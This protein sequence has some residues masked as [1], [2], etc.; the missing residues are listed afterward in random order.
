MQII[1]RV[2]KTR[3]ETTQIHIQNKPTK[4][5]NNKSNDECLMV[6]KKLNCGG[7]DFIS[8]LYTWLPHLQ[9]YFQREYCI[10]FNEN[11]DHG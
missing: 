9:L 5:L 10:N 3:N 2:P 4:S 11:S 1:R 6:N 8:E 7:Y